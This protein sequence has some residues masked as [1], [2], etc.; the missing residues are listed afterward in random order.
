MGGGG[1]ID[2][3][4][5]LTV[6]LFCFF[7]SLLFLV[8]EKLAKILVLQDV[9]FWEDRVMGEPRWE[10]RSWQKPHISFLP[11]LTNTDHIVP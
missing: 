5:C 3:H 7:N 11:C 9:G 6:Y 10:C 1:L 4:N 8:V 2:Y